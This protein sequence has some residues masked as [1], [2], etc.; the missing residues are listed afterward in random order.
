MQFD[1]KM[2]GLPTFQLTPVALVPQLH[3]QVFVIIRFVKHI[4]LLVPIWYQKIVS[5]PQLAAQSHDCGNLEPW[6]VGNR[7]IAAT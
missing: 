7:T 4:V 3:N 1:A 6:F 5:A 2:S